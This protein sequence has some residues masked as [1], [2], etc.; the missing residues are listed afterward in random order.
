MPLHADGEPVLIDCLDRLDDAVGRLG[1][2]AELGAGRLDG[3]VM[4]AVDASL[5]L[6]PEV[7]FS[8]LASV[9][10]IASSGACK[11]FHES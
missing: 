8:Y 4:A 7:S 10:F 11:A 6:P 9:A 2:D 5:K 3:L 1:A